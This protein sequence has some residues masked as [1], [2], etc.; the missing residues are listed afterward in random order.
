MDNILRVCS[1]DWR[2]AFSIDMIEESIVNARRDANVL[3]CDACRAFLPLQ[4]KGE[5]GEGE[6]ES[7]VKM[8][9]RCWMPQL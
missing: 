5:R 7:N 1:A 8:K 9:M 3:L 2:E 6:R 4:I